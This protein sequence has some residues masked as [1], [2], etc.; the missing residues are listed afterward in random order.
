MWNKLTFDYVAHVVLIVNAIK[1]ILLI[2]QIYMKMGN[3]LEWIELCR[4]FTLRRLVGPPG[5]IGSREAK[6]PVIK[7]LSFWLW[8]R[9]K[10]KAGPHGGR[11]KERLSWGRRMWC[12][13]SILWIYFLGKYLLFSRSLKNLFSFSGRDSISESYHVINTSATGTLHGQ[14]GGPIFKIVLNDP[15][16]SA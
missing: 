16:L 8:N 6:S 12:Y 15:V 7:T 13:L 10:T 1:C 2:F 9:E 14:K 3:L 5:L 4:L 11:T